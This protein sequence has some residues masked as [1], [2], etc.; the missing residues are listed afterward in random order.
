MKFVLTVAILF[1]VSSQG[2]LGRFL[3]RRMTESDR[4]NGLEDLLS[5]TLPYLLEREKTGLV[6]FKMFVG[7][8]FHVNVNNTEKWHTLI[9][10]LANAKTL[11]DVANVTPGIPYEALKERY[12]QFQ[13][14]ISASGGYTSAWRTFHA[15]ADFSNMLWDSVQNTTSPKKLSEAIDLPT[16]TRIMEVMQ[17]KYGSRWVGLVMESANENGLILDPQACAK[18]LYESNSGE[19]YAAKQKQI[20]G[21]DQYRLQLFHIYII[22]NKETRAVNEKYIND[23]GRIIPNAITVLGSY[24]LLT[25]EY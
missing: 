2:C 14:S 7:R 13:D 8:T 23:K 10:K 18:E 5:D 1:A 15:L 4:C 3:G 6:E 19:E 25:L 11:R 17:V 21:L 24:G 16:L 12:A 9:C 22:G 20:S